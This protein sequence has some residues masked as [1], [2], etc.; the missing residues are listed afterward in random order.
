M[1]VICVYLFILLPLFL[2]CA[3][4]TDNLKKELESTQ[5][6]LKQI[7][8][9]QVD[10]QKKLEESD[11]KVKEESDR[12]AKEESDRKAKE[13]SDRKAKEEVDAKKWSNILQ[14][15]KP[16]VVRVQ[17]LTLVGSGFVYDILSDG[18]A[19]ILTNHHV[20]DANGP[21]F[22]SINK[23]SYDAEKIHYD[24]KYDL[25]VLKICCVSNKLNKSMEFYTIN[26][27]DFG[28][29][30]VALG[31]PLASNTIN[32][33]SGLVST[34][35]TIN[36]L[37]YVQTDS[38]INPGNSGG[39]LVNREGKIIGIIT[40]KQFLSSDGRPVEGIAY[41]LSSRE[42]GIWLNRNSSFIKKDSKHIP[43][44]S[45]PFTP[46]VPKTT[47]TKKSFNDPFAPPK[48]G[49]AVKIIETNGVITH[50]AAW[51][52]S[53]HYH[54]SDGEVDI[55][56]KGYSPNLDRW[57]YIVYFKTRTES[58]SYTSAPT[59]YWYNFR[60]DYRG[61]VTLQEWIGSREK[62]AQNV[63]RKEKFLDDISF[64]NRY[65]Q[66]NIK[67][68]FTDNITKIYINGNIIFN[69]LDTGG[70]GWEPSNYLNIGVICINSSETAYIYPGEEDCMKGIQKTEY[71]Y[72]SESY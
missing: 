42:I 41:A 59:Y 57:V 55:N 56:F 3:N 46:N 6:Q 40:L 30:V 19:L 22:V 60:I 27:S 13:E 65:G 24:R 61:S 25:A 35:K 69:N 62:G 17:A 34:T 45:R 68:K 16:F 5:T 2:S 8:Q 67:L 21:I 47:T 66:I 43:D 20:V 53:Q 70:D 23:T 1:K 4:E 71:S 18:S 11:R 48:P 9:L 72:K 36:D 49:E 39:P 14:N 7:E 52:G 44:S 51:T 31:F 37:I 38:A 10:N 50:P 29:E 32:I 28:S 54:H 33:T 58:N 64:L 12:K 63:N 15:K 26:D